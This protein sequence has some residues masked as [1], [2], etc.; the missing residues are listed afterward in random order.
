[1]EI[2]VMVHSKEALDRVLKMTSSLHETELGNWHRQLNNTISRTILGM[3]TDFSKIYKLCVAFNETA[4]YYEGLFENARES[5]KRQYLYRCSV[6]FFF[7][8][9]EVGAVTNNDKFTKFAAFE[10]TV[11]LQGNECINPYI[12]KKFDY[13]QCIKIINKFTG[14]VDSNDELELLGLNSALLLGT[15]GL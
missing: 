13:R 1:M 11:D 15:G 14:A 12:V 7:I 3:K 4:K 9:L 8:A 10:E 2:E 6:S 5:Q